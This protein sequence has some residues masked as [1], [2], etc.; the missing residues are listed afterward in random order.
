MLHFYNFQ[1]DTAKQSEALKARLNSLKRKQSLQSDHN[2]V[3]YYLF[4]ITCILT[5][6]VYC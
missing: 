6:S 2:E 3:Y 1:C 4:F 5:F